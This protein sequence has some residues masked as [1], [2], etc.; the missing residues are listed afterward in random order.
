MHQLLNLNKKSLN[1]VLLLIFF[2]SISDF[3][4]SQN[5]DKKDLFSKYD[6]IIGDDNL[7]YSNGHVHLNYDKT[8][9]NQHRYISKNNFSKGS[10][11]YNNQ[12]FDNL[13]LNYD[14]FE[15]QLVMKIANKNYDLS[16]NLIKEKV[17]NFILDNSLFENI[18][19]KNIPSGFYQNL[20]NGDGS[21]FKIFVKHS[22]KKREIIDNNTLV[23]EYNYNQKFYIFLNGEYSK[24][25]TKKDIL[26][27]FPTLEEKINNFYQMNNVLDKNDKTK[28]V[29]NL[30]QFLYNT[31]KNQL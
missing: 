27:L 8:I 20:F 16:I 15:D 2:L 6:E 23:R 10:I 30:A 14:I 21:N 22:K 29:Q 24:F 9:N 7:S 11:V 26:N 17:S 4:F 3:S 28:F 31:T 19:S 12:N 13:D 1:F 25:D 18:D 5:N